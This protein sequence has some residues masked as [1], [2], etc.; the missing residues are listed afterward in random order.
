M[1]NIR[2]I[3]QDIIWLSRLLYYRWDFFK[4]DQY[5]DVRDFAVDTKQN[6]PLQRPRFFCDPVQFSL[7]NAPLI[8]NAQTAFYEI[9]KPQAAAPVVVCK[10][11][12]T[13]PPTTFVPGADAPLVLDQNG[14]EFVETKGDWA[15]VVAHFYERISPQDFYHTQTGWRETV[16]LAQK[17][18]NIPPNYHP[19]FTWDDFH[20]YSE[21][22]S[23]AQQ[24]LISNHLKHQE[25]VLF[26]EE[27]Y[28][29]QDLTLIAPP[30]H[31]PEDSPYAQFIFQF[32]LGMRDRA[33]LVL[34]LVNQVQP[35][36]LLPLI[37]K[38]KEYPDLGGATG[39][40]FNGFVPTGETYLFLMA[41]RDTFKRQALIEFLVQESVLVQEGWVSLS[42]VL[43]GEPVFSGALG[44]HPEQI[45]F[46]LN[47]TL[48]NQ[49]NIKSLN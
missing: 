44:F 25:E 1:S 41:W 39:Q 47:L 43:P 11:E 46:L 23:D 12:V 6:H 26:W 33:L 22:W 48:P 4:C 15:K 5:S 49:T 28:T 42:E 30:T 8:A 37:Q 10:R 27:L 34:S 36:F 3:H 38:T 31:D 7:A 24:E 2:N 45:A 16:W 19:R 9:L 14:F 32:Q 21:T 29:T 40:N 20:A 17:Y 35:D 13:V 18:T